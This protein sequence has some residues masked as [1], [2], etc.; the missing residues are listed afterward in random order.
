MLT[1]TRARA[2]TESKADGIKMKR[3]RG[4]GSKLLRDLKEVTGY[5]HI[6]ALY[7]HSKSHAEFRAVRIYIWTRVRARVCA[8][9][10]RSVEIVFSSFGRR[11]RR[12]SVY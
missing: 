6:I 11:R 2:A 7:Q 9:H 5:K 10:R 4:G 3:G 1:H 8:R 12:A